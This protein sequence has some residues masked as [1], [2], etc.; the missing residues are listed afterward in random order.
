MQIKQP[1]LA[2]QLKKRISPLYV[3]IGQ[4][5]FLIEEALHQ[6]KAA[7]KAAHDSEE[8]LLSL[9][10]PEDWNNLIEEANSY[11][12]FSETTLLNCVYDKKTLEASGKKAL[13][14]YLNAINSRCFLIIRAPNIPAKQWTWLNTHEQVT[15]VVA[16]PFNADAMKTWISLQLQKHGL[17]FE[18]NIPDLIHHY[19]QGNML[20][21]AQAIE[22][23]SLTCTADSPITSQQALEHLHD[24]CE[25]SVFELAEACLLGQAD[26]AIH[27]LRQAANNKTEATLVLWML[28]QEI[29]V[30]SQLSHSLKRMDFS[31]AANQLKIWPQR[32][33]FYQRALK[34]CNPQVLSSLLHYCLS[35]DERIKSSFNTQ[36]W[37]SLENLALSLCL[38]TLIGDTCAA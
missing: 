11:S 33:T 26:K 34:R 9:Q 38:G 31:T 19:T 3:L 32:N 24:Q 35:I 29:R 17:R 8:K 16:Y 2:Q 21:C 6:I 5:N 23:M 36:V 27:I 14:D 12:L 10:S 30:L 15:V 37:N 18:A 20:A 4:D 22:K 1:A 13:T 28:A 25:H 7:I